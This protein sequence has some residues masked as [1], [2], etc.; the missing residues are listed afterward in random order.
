MGVECEAYLQSKPSVEG[1]ISAETTS[2]VV[3]SG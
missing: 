3:N 1:L 2:A